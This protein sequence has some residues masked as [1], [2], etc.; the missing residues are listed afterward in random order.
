MVPTVA[1]V[2]V[3]SSA[4]VAGCGAPEN[5]LSAP[6]RL[7]SPPPPRR[8]L[9]RVPPSFRNRVLPPLIAPL[10]FVKISGSDIET[11]SDPFWAP[12]GAAA[13]VASEARI[14]GIAAAASFCATASLMPSARARPPTNC[15]VR[16]WDTRLTRLIAI[17]ASPRTKKVN[18]REL[19]TDFHAL[20]APW[21]IEKCVAGRSAGRQLRKSRLRRDE[22]LRVLWATGDKDRAR[23][24]Q[25]LLPA[26]V[27]PS[28]H[29]GDE[30]P[31]RLR[32]L[33]FRHRLHRI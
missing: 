11:A 26:L 7:E 5:W 29:V 27:D 8:P 14:A 22:T 10:S 1:W 33:A 31:S 25:N 19:L 17:A 23:K 21:A 15:G 9:R 18:D 6:V 24:G 13:A 12:P 30:T 20:G 2:I 28:K 4:C 16:N 3:P 32:G